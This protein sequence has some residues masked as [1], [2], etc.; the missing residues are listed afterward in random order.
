MLRSRFARPA[1]TIL[2]L[3]CATCSA[4]AM[5]GNLSEG[6]QLFLRPVLVCLLPLQLAALVWVRTHQVRSLATPPLESQPSEN[7][8]I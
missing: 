1:A 6:S 2:L 3:G 7:S 5:G 8:P 4:A